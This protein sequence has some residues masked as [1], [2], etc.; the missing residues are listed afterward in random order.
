[1]FGVLVLAAALSAGFADEGAQ[2][3][4]LPGDPPSVQATASAPAAQP[5][6]VAAPPAVASED[7]RLPA[8]TVVRIELADAVNS[9]D[10]ARGDKFAIRLAQPI[11]IDGKVLA[12][13]GTPGGGEVVYAERASGGGAPGKLVLAAR[14][15]DVGSTRVHLKA[16]NLAAGGESEFTEMR[17]ASEIIGP[18]VFLINGHN[19][20]Y[21]AGTRARAKVAEDVSLPGVATVPTPESAPSTAVTPTSAA[22]PPTANVPTSM[23]T[24][25]EP[26]K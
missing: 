7:V 22:S 2:S 6:Y 9:K 8:E 21:P 5:S 12:P 19:V 13:A 25:P 26:P 1:M 4:T 16:F 23:T 18:G 15:I 3:S 10:R 20:L 14:Y 11:V 17:V 24:T